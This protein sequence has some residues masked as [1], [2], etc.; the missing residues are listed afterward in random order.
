VIYLV[1]ISGGLVA[2]GSLRAVQTAFGPVNVMLVGVTAILIPEFSRVPGSA[3]GSRRRRAVA[4]ASV[5]APG[6]LLWG[7]LLAVTPAGVGRS[8]LGSTWA[9]IPPLLIWTAIEKAALGAS[10]APFAL[11]RSTRNAQRGLRLRLLVAGA[12]TVCGGV[13]ALSGAAVGAAKGFAVAGVASSLLWWRAANRELAVE[14][15]RAAD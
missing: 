8:L 4:A 10:A 3:V 11:L 9:F 5:L 1:A 15:S 6:A 13:G 2:A 12:T 7:V 14:G